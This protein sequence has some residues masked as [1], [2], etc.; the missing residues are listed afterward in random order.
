MMAPYRT[1]KDGME[2][3]RKKLN[4]STKESISYLDYLKKAIKK[5]K[6]YKTFEQFHKEKTKTYVRKRKTKISTINK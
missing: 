6:N 5:D 4:M 1:R 2:E 3:A